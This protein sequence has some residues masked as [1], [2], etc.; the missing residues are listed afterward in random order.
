MP[1]TICL[2]AELPAEPAKIY[3]MYLDRRLHTAFTGAPAIVAP[4]EGAKFSAFG[5][6]LTGKILQLVPK[7][8]IVQSWRSPAWKDSDIDSTLVLSLRPIRG[9]QTLIELTH[10]NVSEQDFAGVSQ[11]W[12]LYYWAPWREYLKK[13]RSTK[14]GALTGSAAR[15]GSRPRSTAG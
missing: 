12:E 7:R 15:T 11:G 10:L 5:G 2:A 8:L 9:K 4:R 1:H 3:D 14:P 6:T 13:G